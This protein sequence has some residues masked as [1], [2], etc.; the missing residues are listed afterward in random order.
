[1]TD[2]EFIYRSG[3][4]NKFNNN[5]NNKK[6]LVL[7]SGPSARE[8]NWENYNYDILVTTSFFYLNKRVLESNASHVSLSKLVDLKNKDLIDYLDKNKDCT[9]SFEPKIK[10]YLNDRYHTSS[11][12]AG[13]AAKNVHNF[14]KTKE[15]EI[16]LKKYHDR[17]LFFRIEGGLEGLAGR[18]CWLTLNAKPKEILICGIDGIS[19]DFKNDPVN[20][21][22]KHKGMGNT[23]SYEA[24]LESYLNFGKKLYKKASENNIRVVNLGE[25][26]EYNMLTQVSK[27][28]K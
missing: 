21:F 22:R 7:G 13:N 25:G 8:I 3:N 23:R 1:M 20:A 9:I 18:L 10:N 11:L 5:I 6:V 15:Y 17:M 26:K 28:Y 16:F 2:I 27:Q 4:F 19:K 14:Y 12:L 24:Y